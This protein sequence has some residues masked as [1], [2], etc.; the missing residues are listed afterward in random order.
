[1]AIH[2]YLVEVPKTK[3]SIK[4]AKNGTNYV[5]YSV[6]TY[7]NKNNT[8]THRERAIGKL[9]PDDPTTMYP[10][11]NYLELFGA[12][13]KIEPIQTPK[14]HLA[15]ETVFLKEIAEMSGL[16]EVLKKVF[17]DYY[18][19]ILNLAIYIVKNGGVMMNLEDYYLKHV[20]AYDLVPHSHQ[21]NKFFEELT[22]DRHWS[23][24]QEWNKYLE[25]D[26]SYLA[27]DV[28]SVST[29]SQNIPIAERGYNRDG[30]K[31]DQINFGTFFDPDKC[32]PVAYEVY[33]ESI[34]DKTHFTSS[35][36]LSKILNFKDVCWVLDG[37]FMTEGNLEQLEEI[38]EEKFIMMAPLT[39][40]KFKNKVLDEVFD[41]EKVDNYCY[42]TAAN[43][44]Q[45]EIEINGSEYQ[46]YIFRE[47]MRAAEEKQ[48]IY[49][50]IKQEDETLAKQKGIKKKSFSSKYHNLEQV[51]GELKDYQ[52]NNEKIEENLELAGTF[53]ILTKGMDKHPNQILAIYRRRNEIEGFFNGMKNTLDTDRLRIHSI[54]AMDGKM[55]VTFIALIIH[56]YLLNYER[57]D[58]PSDRNAPTIKALLLELEKITLYKY[59][60]RKGVMAPLTKKQR[61]ILEDYGINPDEFIEKVCEF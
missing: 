17:P 4:T 61:D 52:K 13:E 25:T 28:T 12:P 40:N 35:L 21:L 8:P 24:F 7:R 50:R 47:P 42:S 56:S 43:G 55:F 39:Q 11:D 33:N 34:P 46:L 32:L 10:N 31:L 58:M 19:E 1:M 57:S 16:E 37:G 41:L 44:K 59:Q 9:N 15:A 60:G 6:E 22:I 30:E 45:V 29:Y 18:R 38:E 3:T 36:E 54:S 51:K 23:F 48:T 14:S 26:T 20:L 27:Y 5:Y 2:N 53:A 49:Q